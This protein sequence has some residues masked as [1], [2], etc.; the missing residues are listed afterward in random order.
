MPGVMNELIESIGTASKK[1]SLQTISWVSLSLL[2]L[3]IFRLHSYYDSFG[4][5]I[6]P[7]LE[8]S[9]IVFSFSNLLIRAIYVFLIF[10]SF[11]IARINAEDVKL[12][13]SFIGIIVLIMSL[14]SVPFSLLVTASSFFTGVIFDW[15]GIFL[16][17]VFGSFIFVV[18]TR[19]PRNLKSRI[20][21]VVAAIIFYIQ[22]DNWM[23]YSAIVGPK[24]I[25]L[26]EIKMKG[27]DSAVV[28]D[29]HLRLIGITRNC[30]F[31]Y[32]LDRKATQVV[33]RDEVSTMFYRDTKLTY[34]EYVFSWAK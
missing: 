33:P 18:V 5:D 26:I 21:I 11:S 16:L 29:D 13:R 2:L 6:L 19:S 3:G 1:I 23:K 30:I 34:L 27:S 9:E 14:I 31:L 22:M 28:T 24:P 15:K 8:T 32:D 4:V 17:V 25:D 7:Y 12:N 10:C 20:T